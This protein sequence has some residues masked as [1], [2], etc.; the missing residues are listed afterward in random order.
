MK[1]H[2]T[3]GIFLLLGL[4]VALALTACS[5]PEVTGQTLAGQWAPQSA[6]LG[7]QALPVASFKGATLRL[8]TDTYEFA[9]DKGTIALLPASS[10]ASMDIHGQEGPNAGR[11]I[12]AIYEL[13]GEQL[14]VCYQLGSGERPGEFKSAK[15]S[16]VLLIHYKRVR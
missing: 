15:G 10:P 8:T 6:E 1:Q 16:K 4:M 12:Q 9:G 14:T 2:F 11:T 13:A 5:S 7:G 3:R